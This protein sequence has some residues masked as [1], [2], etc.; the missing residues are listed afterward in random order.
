MTGH[1]VT[2]PKRLGVNS[3]KDTAF[4]PKP[5]PSSWR[6]P[7]NIKARDSRLFLLPAQKI[8]QAVSEF[9]GKRR[10]SRPQGDVFSTRMHWPPLKQ[11]AICKKVFIHSDSLLNGSSSVGRAIATSHEVQ[12]ILSQEWLVQNWEVSLY[13]DKLFFI[14]KSTTCHHDYLS[15]RRLLLKFNC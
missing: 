6:V 8:F 14:G 13:T 11:H 5:R 9:L 10:R 15:Q 12:N 1:R 3:K 4:A 7:L 2:S